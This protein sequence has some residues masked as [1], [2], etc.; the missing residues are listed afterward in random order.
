ME[1]WRVICGVGFW[2]H[3]ISLAEKTQHCVQGL[4]SEKL[5]RNHPF[6]NMDSRKP[7]L[8][9]LL[10]S[11]QWAMDA[12]YFILTGTLCSVL[13]EQFSS[14]CRRGFGVPKKWSSLPKSHSS[15]IRIW[16]LQ[17]FLEP[18]GLHMPQRPHHLTPNGAV[19]LPSPDSPMSKSPLPPF[20]FSV[21][22]KYWDLH[23][24]FWLLDLARSLREPMVIEINHRCR[25]STKHWSAHIGTKEPGNWEKLKGQSWRT[26]GEVG[27]FP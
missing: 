14:F 1:G 25:W 10:S 15:Q 18:F 17:L 16:T 11:R 20:C 6:H 4:L 9:K 21:V 5:S 8:A 27:V 2:G 23:E 24:N 3:R 7:M 22:Q 13:W 26:K 12:P 19:T